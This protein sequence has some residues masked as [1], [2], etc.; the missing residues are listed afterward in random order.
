MTVAQPLKRQ[1][2][3]LNHLVDE[4]AVDFLDSATRKSQRISLAQT[5][6]PLL[7]QGDGVLLKKALDNLLSNAL[8]YTQSGGDVI[9]GTQQDEDE[10]VVFVQDTG[11]GIHPDEIGQLF[12]PF[13]RL[14]SAGDEYGTGLGLSLVKLIVERHFGRVS[15]ESVL[16]TGSIFRIHLP[17]AHEPLD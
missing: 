9:I 10:C 8:K 17:A 7:V 11:S 14:S 2:I 15:V 1:P 12:Q 3:D 6:E 13:Q 4:A 16:G 5:V